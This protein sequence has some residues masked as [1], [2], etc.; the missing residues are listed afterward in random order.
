[1]K[2]QLSDYKFKRSNFKNIY[3]FNVKQIFDVSTM[4]YSPWR[5]K[6]LEKVTEGGH[7]HSG[8]KGAPGS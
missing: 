2:L 5:L 8:Q 3:I 4:W 6:P 7:E 1:M